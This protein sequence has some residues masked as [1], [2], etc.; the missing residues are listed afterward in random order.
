MYRTIEFWWLYIQWGGYS[1]GVIRVMS[2]QIWNAWKLSVRGVVS[3]YI[4]VCL[5][6]ESMRRY[7]GCFANPD[8]IAAVCPDTK[9]SHPLLSFIL[10]LL[11]NFH[12]NYFSFFLIYMNIHLFIFYHLNNNN[13]HIVIA[14]CWKRGRKK[15]D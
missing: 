2:E 4:N 8:N 15:N 7:I 1:W 12:F 6:F 9:S 14:R 3:L 13:T 5:P 10:I 11:K